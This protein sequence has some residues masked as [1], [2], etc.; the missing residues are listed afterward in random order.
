MSDLPNARATNATFEFAALNEARNYRASLVRAF[1][2]QLH[3]RVIEV[4]AG[5]G[6]ITALLHA[7]A[8]VT[9]VV[10]VEP[11]PEFCRQ[12]RAALPTIE[13]VHGT[14][15][16]LGAEAGGD[17]LVSVNV[18]E[19]IEHD[20]R[21]LRRYRELLAARRG[22]LC[23]FVPARPELYAPLDREFG[24]FRRYTRP[25]LRAKL[26]A[27]G[28]QIV[29]LDYF[30]WVGYFAWWLRFRVQRQLT[31]NV[32]DVRWFD[33]WIFPAVN[34]METHLSPPPFG[35]SLLAIARAT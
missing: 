7:Q 3:G 9:Q 14:V 18:L 8:A 34:W 23:L 5:I 17:A 33:R 28:F 16:A 30:N 35:Q 21:E 1:A 31:F 29:R 4:G 26:H 27:A 12:L 2:G 11:D 13:L 25:E 15:D 6:Q 32:R 19:H 24:H 20:A 10:A 22:A